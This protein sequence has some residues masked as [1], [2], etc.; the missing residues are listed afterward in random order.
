[1]IIAKYID[2]EAMDVRTSGKTRRRVDA[3][4][5]SFSCPPDDVNSDHH[6]WMCR[7]EVPRGESFCMNN[8]ESKSA[9][10]AACG[11]DK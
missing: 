3:Y 5:V 8:F 4:F 11:Y 7:F 2:R 1:M 10:R 9:A 6:E